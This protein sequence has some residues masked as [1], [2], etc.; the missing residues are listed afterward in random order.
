[1]LTTVAYSWAKLSN[2]KLIY[3][4]VLNISCNLLSAVLKVKSRMVVSVLVVTIMIVCG[5]LVAATAGHIA[6]LNIT[7]LGKDPNSKFKVWFLLNVHC[8]YT[9]V[10]WKNCNSE[11]VNFKEAAP[12]PPM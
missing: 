10:K 12:S 6:T 4:K 8:F 11:T 3:N 1:M 9:I 5:C 2:S 7:N